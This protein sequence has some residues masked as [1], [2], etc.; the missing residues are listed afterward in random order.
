MRLVLAERE[1]GMNWELAVLKSSKV[2]A[3][4]QGIQS[5]LPHDCE[6]TIEEKQE[7]DG[8]PYGSINNAIFYYLT[9]T[10]SADTDHRLVKGIKDVLEAV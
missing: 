2:S 3:A 10:G 4:L 7:N 8:G 5:K 6:V 9:V 1:V